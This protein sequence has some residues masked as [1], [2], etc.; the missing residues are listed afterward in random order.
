MRIKSLAIKIRY[1]IQNLQQLKTKL[2]ILISW[3]TWRS[4]FFLYSTSYSDILSYIEDFQVPGIQ[5][6]ILFLF[7]LE[8]RYETVNK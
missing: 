1:L 3:I 5:L 4:N 8:I 6:Y 7:T 2:N